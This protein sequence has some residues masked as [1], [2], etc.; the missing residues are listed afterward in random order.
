MEYYSSLEKRRRREDTTDD[1]EV[2]SSSTASKNKN[3]QNNDDDDELLGQSIN[4]SCHTAHLGREEQPQK[5]VEEDA[6][7]SLA[8]LHTHTIAIANP[9]ETYEKPSLCNEARKRR[10]SSQ[11]NNKKEMGSAPP[12]KKKRENKSFAQRIEELKAYKKK[13]GNVNVKKGE[14]M[15]L[16]EYCRKMRQARNNPGKSSYIMN[17][18]RIASLDALGFNWTINEREKK[19]F[20]QG[21]DDVECNVM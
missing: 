17:D 11:S 2:V 20:E 18:D 10:S 9:P 7:L 3:P 4:N 1:H 15:S 13:H 8:S 21:I 12:K 19:S 16:Y 6:A 14:D 5:T